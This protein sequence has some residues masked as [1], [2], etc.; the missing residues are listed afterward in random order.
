MIVGWQFATHMR[1]SLVEDALQMAVATRGVRP[2]GLPL[3]FHSD[4]G[5]QQYVAR[6]FT[7]A[8]RSHGITASLGSVGDTYDNALAESFVDSFK[9]ELIRDRVWRTRT[10]LELAIV[11]WIGWYNHDRLHSALG[12]LPPVEELGEDPYK[13]VSVEPGMLHT[14][15]AP[16]IESTT[17]MEGW[18]YAPY[19]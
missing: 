9:T 10:Q 3:I 16:G 11:E 8:L 15:G 12:Y 18:P 6:D 2:G 4:H 5:S 19:S 1:E 17:I 14:P 13:P 7:A